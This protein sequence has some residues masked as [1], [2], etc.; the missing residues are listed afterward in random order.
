MG[1]LLSTHSVAGDRRRVLGLVT[2]VVALVS[3][4]M[5]ALSFVIDLGGAERGLIFA[6]MPLLFYTGAAAVLL[7]KQGPPEEI[8]L[9]EDGI[10]HV[11][12]GVRQS[13][14]WDQ[15]RALD[16][17]EHAGHSKAGCMIRFNDGQLLHISGL[18]ENSPAIV[19]A[20]T[21]RCLDARREPV[22]R[23]HK[24]RGAAGL[25]GVALVCGGVATWAVV[26][27][28]SGDPFKLA[29]PA[30]ALAIPAVISLTLLIAVL[31]TGRR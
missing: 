13:W 24:R 10:V 18:T 7:V 4:A 3:A 15:V 19:T 12:G 8:E 28:L 9:H 23:R 26:A 27:Q 22:R 2:A 20:L 6:V 14:A 5:L 11:L 16:V 31:V 21:T 25:G 30:V 29:R 17:A 1:P